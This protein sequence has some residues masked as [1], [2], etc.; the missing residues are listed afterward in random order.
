MLQ[1]K[2]QEKQSK[3]SVLSGSDAYSQPPSIIDTLRQG[4]D[5]DP[6]EKVAPFGSGAIGFV[7]VVLL[8]IALIA[9]AVGLN[10]DAAPKP[11]AVRRSVLTACAVV[12]RAAACCV[13]VM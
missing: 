11:A 5:V 3:S 4:D 1:E 10:N 7:G 2:E 6:K 12:H 8:A 9:G 13:R